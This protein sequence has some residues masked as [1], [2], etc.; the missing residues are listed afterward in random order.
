MHARAPAIAVR[1][2]P[3]RV[4]DPSAH[5]TTMAEARAS[6]RAAQSAPPCSADQSHTV[7]SRTAIEARAS[8]GGP[9]HSFEGVNGRDTA[10]GSTCTTS[11]AGSTS[12][13]SRP[14]KQHPVSIPRQ[15]TPALGA[16]DLG[17]RR[18]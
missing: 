14:P 10:F 2:P 7:K 4:R 1:A 13:V 18:S 16:S 6:S 8:P 15:R 12:A 3:Q 11:S 9:P 17:S 5:P